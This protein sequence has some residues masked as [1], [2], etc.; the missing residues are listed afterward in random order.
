M[1]LRA[2]WPPARPAPPQSRRDGIHHRR[3]HR[4]RGT[5]STEAPVQRLPSGLSLQR[6]AAG[7]LLLH[8]RRFVHVRIAERDIMGA[9]HARTA[10]NSGLPAVH[11]P[12]LQLA[13]ARTTEFVHTTV[14][15]TTM[16][17]DTCR[18]DSAA[19]SLAAMADSERD[20]V[21]RCM[22]RL[23]GHRWPCFRRL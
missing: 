22:R 17:A 5:R 13:G 9:E 15:S 23:P 18:T 20:M 16:P 21:V 8:H 4:K 1:A 6:R 2:L 12:C 19:G 3:L 10:V 7:R 11:S 14:Q